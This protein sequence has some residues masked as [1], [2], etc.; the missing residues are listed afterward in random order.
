MTGRGFVGLLRLD[1]AFPRPVGDVGNPN[2]FDFPV[3][4]RVV[5]GASAA[6]VVRGDATALLAPFI[7]A[8]RALASDGAVAIGTSCGFLG[9]FQRELADALPVPFAASAL[10]QLAWLAPLLPRGRRAGV[11][12]IDADALDARHLAAAGAPP[13]TPVVGLRRDGALAR[14][15]FGDAPRLDRERIRD[16]VVEAGLRLRAAVPGLGA[17]VLECTNLPPYRDAL[18]RAV[19]VPV[20]DCNT[21]LRWLWAGA[22]RPEP[23]EPSR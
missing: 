2:T 17:I 7:E 1:T 13:D 22:A 5:R 3:R 14:A 20:H 16:E 8:G 23:L 19:G 4:S 21:L 10:L 6:R 9:P 18:A 15:V 11:I 12:T